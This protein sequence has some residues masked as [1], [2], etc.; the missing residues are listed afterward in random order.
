MTVSAPEDSASRRDVPVHD[1]D[2]DRPENN[3]FL[4]IRQFRVELPGTQHKTI[5]PDVVLFVNGIPLVAIEAKAIGSSDLGA[6]LPAL[7]HPSV[8]QSDGGEARQRRGT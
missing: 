1:I 2:W 5:R 6:A 8:D 4:V 3:E 7:P